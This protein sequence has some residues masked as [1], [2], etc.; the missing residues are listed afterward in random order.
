MGSTPSTRNSTGERSVPSGGAIRSGGGYPPGVR[1]LGIVVNVLL[2]VAL[3]AMLRH[4]RRAG[5]DDQRF[6][7]KGI[8]SRAL[9]LVPLASGSVPLLWL[10]RRGPYPV[11]MDSL[12]LSVVALDLAG[13]V[14]DL[15]DGYK[16]FDLIPHT[17]G[18]GAMTVLAAWLFR[19]PM[20]SA[21]GVATV[22]HVL[23]EVQEYASDVAFGYR[24]V[25]GTW[26][27]IGDLSAGIVGTAVYSMAYRRVVRDR[28]LE[29]ASPF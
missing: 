21:V 24:N 6:A 26:D 10:R 19:L 2:R 29:P 18:T 28:G 12:C 13:N 1:I 27:V 5:G 8:G 23:L 16:H 4:V 7:A 25:R 17:H 11:W 3:L 15:Y 20:L 14:F 9:L 22:G